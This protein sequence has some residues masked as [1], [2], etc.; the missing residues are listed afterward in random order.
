MRDIASL[1]NRVI[2]RTADLPTPL[3]PKLQLGNARLF[4]SSCFANAALS[5]TH[6]Q[7]SEASKTKCVPKLELGNE[8]GVV[9]RDRYIRTRSALVAGIQ[10]R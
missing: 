3:V 8:G 7:R 1:H 5:E 10:P 4:R 2:S 9:G 6:E